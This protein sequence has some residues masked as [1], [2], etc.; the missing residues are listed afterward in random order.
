MSKICHLYTFNSPWSGNRSHRYSF[1]LPCTHHDKFYILH[2]QYFYNFK[3]LISCT[4]V[5]GNKVHIHKCKSCNSLHCSNTRHNFNSYILRMCGRCFCIRQSSLACIL[6]SKLIRH[7]FNSSILSNLWIS[8]LSLRFDARCSSRYQH[9][10][11][12]IHSHWLPSPCPMSSLWST[13]S[14][15]IRSKVLYDLDMCCLYCKKGSYLNLT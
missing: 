11:R 9:F 6:S 2:L 15:Y 1:Y 10:L 5:Q 12:Y 8:N 14:L 4:L 7:K 13:I 3:W